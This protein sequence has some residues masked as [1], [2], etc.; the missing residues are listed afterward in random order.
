[1]NKICP[2]LALLATL[3]Y[4]APALATN[5]S[6]GCVETYSAAS[7][8]TSSDDV[9]LTCDATDGF[10]FWF[11]LG[12]RHQ[13]RFYWHNTL[14]WPSDY[15]EDSLGGSDVVEVDWS[16]ADLAV[17]SGHG[18]CQNPPLASSPDFIVTAKNGIGRSA[19]FV[20]INA[21]LRL[22]EFPGSGV[23]GQNGNLN[24]LMLNASCPMDLVS[25]TTQWRAV[26]Q[27]MH[28]AMGHSGDVN[29][30]NLDSAS[31]LPT[32]GLYLSSLGGNS[33][34]RAAWMSAGLIDVQPGVCAVITS[35]GRTES[36]AIARRDFE[37]PTGAIGDAMPP[38]WLAWRY[39]CS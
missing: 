16:S 4:C 34:Y 28:V 6:M 30:D 20:N 19:N 33:S 8:F 13:L 37:T 18:S 5:Y 2:T 35:A 21:A 14:V 36:E 17:F 24:A 12:N 38:T 27:G 32:V 11:N 23:F 9:S 3:A 39:V 31:K 10:S 1:M 22:G 7:G 26:Y 29:H 15:R 25:L